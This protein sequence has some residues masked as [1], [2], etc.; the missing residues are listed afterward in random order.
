MQRNVE[1]IWNHPWLFWVLIL[2]SSTV[3]MLII[4][5]ASRWFEFLFNNLYIWVAMIGVIFIIP[6]LPIRETYVT[7]L[8]LGVGILFSLYYHKLGNILK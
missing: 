6:F 3:A 2:V 4:T 8:E 1:V 5:S 7:Y